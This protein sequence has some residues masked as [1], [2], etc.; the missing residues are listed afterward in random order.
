MDNALFMSKICRKNQNTGMNINQ[1][2]EYVGIAAFIILPTSGPPLSSRARR[3][4][5]ALS[6]SFL[7]PI[8]FFIGVTRFFTC[9]LRWDPTLSLSNFNISSPLSQVY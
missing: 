6:F 2:F 5:M 4:F 8:C 9:V 3:V 7:L 1:L